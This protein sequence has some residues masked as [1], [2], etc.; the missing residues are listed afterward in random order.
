M[1]SLLLILC[2]LC[3]FTLSAKMKVVVSFSILKDFVEK[4]GGDEVEVTSLV[5]PNSDA[6]VFEPTPGS[7]KAITEAD[8]VVTNGLGFEG[9]ID[10]LIQATN[11]KGP[12]LIAS[13]GITP[14]Q[15]EG[16]AEAV[17][18]PHA[19]HDVVHAT[20]Y[21]RNILKGLIDHD[22]IHK[23]VYERYAKTYL[24]T[25][26]ELHAW[27]EKELKEVPAEKRRLITAHDA[28]HY[29]AERYGI[30]VL[31]AQGISTEAQPSAKEIADLVTQIK[32]EGIKALFVENIS[33]TKLMAQIAKETGVVPSGTLYSDALGESGGEAETYEKMMRHNVMLIKNA[34]SLNE[35]KFSEASPQ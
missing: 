18:D 4:V 27:I 35:S 25:L 31:S 10:R 17:P 24:K 12:I 13:E 32:S 21:V 9:W 23:D 28:F 20:A 8:L 2:L 26:E 11:Y 1:K 14:R 19:W 22:P 6:H 16:S 30:Q 34:I 3:P 33:N 5:G 7:G 29:F 15:A